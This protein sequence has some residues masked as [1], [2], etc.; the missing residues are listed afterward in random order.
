MKSKNLVLSVSLLALI[1]CQTDKESASSADQPEAA[2][3]EMLPDDITTILEG[4]IRK[5]DFLSCDGYLVYFESENYCV[6]EVPADWVPFEFN[7]RTY[8][9]QPLSEDGK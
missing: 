1:A 7:G 8:Y 6:S 5:G 3:P 9:K 2:S 4:R